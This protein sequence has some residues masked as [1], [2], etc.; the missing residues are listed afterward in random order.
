M[1]MSRRQF[2][3]GFTGKERPRRQLNRAAAIDAFV[4]TNLLP[5]DFCLT[6]QQVE[7]LLGVVRSEMTEGDGTEFSGEERQRMA[8]IAQETIEPWR[9]DYCKAEEKRRDAMVLV[10]EFL[11]TEAAPETSK[12]QPN[13]FQIP[14]SKTLEE[15]EREA[16]SWLY[17]LPDAR[18]ASLDAADLK[19]LVFSE[20]SIRCQADP[21]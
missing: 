16:L 19:D 14:S 3:G 6:D 4:R 8:T 5:Y 1:R 7:H 13:R 11:L 18:L 10:R 2:F 12:R 9:E 17:G 21:D 15:I 20:M